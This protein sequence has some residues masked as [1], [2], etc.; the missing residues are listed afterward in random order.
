[1][2]FILF[3]ILLLAS[4]VAFILFK[5][6]VLFDGL[7]VLLAAT[8]FALLFYAIGLL[9]QYFHRKLA[10][11]LVAALLVFS[12]LIRVLLAALYNFS[13]RGFSSEF[14]GHIELKSFQVALGEYGAALI[15]LL[16]VVAATA[17]TATRLV[18]VHA[19]RSVKFTIPVF[20]VA[21]GLIY[22]GS[23]G[24][25]EISLVSTMPSGASH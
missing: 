9:V 5:N 2:R 16:F 4:P 3:S 15:V 12:L 18:H 21:C 6:D 7:S 20:M 8:G 14:F 13:G 19:R 11:M 23:P 17:Y 25:P 1:M 24:S 22:A 10:A